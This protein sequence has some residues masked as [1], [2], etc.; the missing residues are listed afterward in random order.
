MKTETSINQ[1]NITNQNKMK[2]QNIN[3]GICHRRVQTGKACF[4]VNWM[5]DGEN[6]YKF[7]ELRSACEVFKKRLVKMQQ[8]VADPKLTN[9]N[10]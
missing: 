3:I 1:E 2:I 5:Q 6:N 7:F 4:F 8:T 9:I 10:N